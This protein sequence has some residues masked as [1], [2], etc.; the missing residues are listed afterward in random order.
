MTTTINDIKYA[1]R[2]LTKRPGFTVTVILILALGIGANTAIFSVVHAV[3]FKR[4]PYENPEGIV[5]I[6]EQ[7]LPQGVD[8]MKSSHRN[9]LYWRKHAESFAHIAGI[10]NFR[11][12]LTGLNRPYHLKG[13]R[14]SACFFEVMG[15]QPLLGRTFLPE[16]ENTGKEHVIVL[17]HAFWRE[18]MGANPQ[19]VG[20]T[21]NLD[22]ESYTVVGVMPPQFQQSLTRDVP[23]WVPLVLD[24][25]GLGGGTRVWAR[26]KEGKSLAQAQAEMNILEKRIIEMDPRL[27]GY[28]V[29][30]TH[31]LEDEL[32]ESRTLLYTLWGAAL[33]V[34]L[35][36][37]ANTGGL[38]LVNANT[39]RRELAIRAAL[40]AS[41]FS[42]L[43][44]MFTEG[45]IL[46]AVAGSLGLFIAYA[47]V[48][49]LVGVCPAE[50]PRITEAGINMPVLLFSMGTVLLAALVLSMAPAW[51]GAFSQMNPILKGGSS[52][53]SNQ[54]TWTYTRCTLVAAQISMALILLICVGMLIQSL[55]AMQQQDLGY[56]PDHVLVASIELPKAAYP[57]I[58]H[59]KA[60]YQRLLKRIQNLPD[61]E[62]AAL[63]T[64]GLDLGT[65]GGFVSLHIEGRAQQD[66]ENQA[67]TRVN[68]VSPEFFPAMGIRMLKGRV[69]THEEISQGHQVAIINENIAKKFF[70]NENPI[71]QRVNGKTI[72]GVVSVFRD[73]EELSPTINDIF[74]PIVGF[75]YQI[76]DIVVRTQG[77]PLLLTNAL[78]EQVTLIDKHQ[79]ISKIQTLEARLDEMLAPQRFTTLLV[80]LFAQV[81]L[82]L[83]VV[84]LYGLLQYTV[85]QRTRDIGIRMALGATQSQITHSFL[86]R[87]ALLIVIGMVV[88]LIGGA[89]TSRLIASLLYEARFTDSAILMVTVT[90]LF[91]T[92]LTA[93]YIPARRAARIDPME[94]LRYE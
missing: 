7:V 80:S 30:I 4:L 60:F 78:H 63:V 12:Y 92:G 20:K 8:K 26:L 41:R 87:G 72:V 48:K 14:V 10:R 5:C 74:E 43:R 36:T 19:V 15:A 85:T 45:L 24:P 94:A 13:S 89:I 42:I 49:I 53:S 55:I 46:S 70:A 86:R 67:S 58:E 47:A 22:Y 2:I 62:H 88:G 27:S 84:G 54:R 83:S 79:E 66:W 50:I 64:G 40:G 82:V 51:K 39:R 25:Q 75:Y 17:S 21:L 18:H 37:C 56:R 3:L 16:E 29:A 31:F 76:S 35:I 33:L 28:T 81:A 34:L 68:Q 9:I 90:I 61:I 57:E 65:G 73:F 11:T 23:F 6:W 91:I 1:L 69:F 59:A 44:Q 77:D 32:G 38:F 52:E 93:C 71:G